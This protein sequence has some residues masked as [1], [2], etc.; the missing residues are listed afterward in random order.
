MGEE[1]SAAGED[2]VEDDG[3]TNKTAK[4]ARE[5]ADVSVELPAKE[6]DRDARDEKSKDDKKPKAECK[7]SNLSNDLW[8]NLPDV[9]EQ[10]DSASKDI[11]QRRK[12]IFQ[13]KIKKVSAES[14][15]AE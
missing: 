5:K 10:G 12:D 13:S 15:E 1:A 2:A 3:E 14:G 4:E 8:G 7:E 11:W 9:G 6:D